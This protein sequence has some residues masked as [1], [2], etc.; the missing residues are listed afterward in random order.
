M[1]KLTYKVVKHDGG[2]AYQA[3]GTYSEP[4]PTRDAALRAS[5]RLPARQRGFLTRT[6]K[7]AGTKRSTAAPIAR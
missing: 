7:D 5:R 2:W 1:S 3:N 6:K 4:F